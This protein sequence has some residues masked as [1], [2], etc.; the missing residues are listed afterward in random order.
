MT[1]VPRIASVDFLCEDELIVC[2]TDGRLAR[3]RA[4]DIYPCAV[5][6]AGLDSA[7]KEPENGET[8][9]PSS[10]SA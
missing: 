4:E 5:I 3:L 8:P 2:F 9:N 7:E 6:E 10:L 1:S